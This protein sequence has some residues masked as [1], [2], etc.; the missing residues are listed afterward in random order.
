LVAELNLDEQNSALSKSVVF[1]SDVH[2][3]DDVKRAAYRFIDVVSIDITLSDNDIVCVLNFV[4]DTNEDDA[5]KIVNDFKIEVLDQGLR[6]AIA[7]ETKEI[8]NA[9][10]AYAFSKTDLQ[11]S[12]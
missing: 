5:Q 1:S 8:R 4:K 6:R 10:L 11:N 2:G 12:E 3:I 7:E 9:V